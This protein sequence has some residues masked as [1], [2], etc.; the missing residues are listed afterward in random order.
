MAA[1]NWPTGPWKRLHID[2]AGPFQG[3]MFLVII[4]SYSKWLEV[5]PMKSTTS[6]ATINQLRNLFANFGLPEHIVSDNGPQFTSAEFEEFTKKNN[7]RHTLT[8]PAHPA[9]NGMAERYVGFIKSALKKMSKQDA[10]LQ[11]K[12]NRIL[13]TYRC[14]PHPATSETPAYL[15]MCREL[16]TKFSSLRPSLESKKDMDVIEQNTNC[17]P[18]FSTGDKVFVL[19]LRSGPRWLPGIIIEVL[20]RSYYV[21]VEGFPVWKRHEDQLRARTLEGRLVEEDLP[22]VPPTKVPQL[23]PTKLPSNKEPEKTPDIQPQVPPSDFQP[24]GNEP[25]TTEKQAT[26][27]TEGIQ[28]ETAEST[29]R[30]QETEP[31]RY[32]SRLRKQPQR[33]GL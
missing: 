6:T 25:T 14:T 33:Y 16:R 24:K 31:R 11:D 15:L 13:L 5:V 9:T 2:Y 10:T 27:A 20:Q 1:W 18:K 23:L 30:C 21:H 17:V 32:P 22:F 12:L 8:A 3:N 19:N 4:D 28:Q 7:I 26:P 29:E